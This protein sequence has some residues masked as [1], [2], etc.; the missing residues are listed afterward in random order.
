MKQAYL[1]LSDEHRESNY[2]HKRSEPGKC[3]KRSKETI[4]GPNTREL[5]VRF[6]SVHVDTVRFYFGNRAVLPMFLQ[7]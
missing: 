1:Q 2:V 6:P 3:N 5:E 4:T 7:E